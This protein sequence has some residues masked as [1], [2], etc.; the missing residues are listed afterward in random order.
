VIDRWRKFFRLSRREKVLLG[1]A[2]PL[3]PATALALRV[4]GFRRLQA[5]LSG[6]PIRSETAP[7]NDAIEQARRTARM[8]SIAARRGLYQ[9]NCLPQSLV[10]WALLRRQAIESDLRIGVRKENGKFEAHAWIEIQ[11]AALNDLA[12]VGLRFAPFAGAIDLTMRQLGA[13]FR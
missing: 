2:V 9:A 4:I 12:D 5:A 11:G 13:K 1:L 8:V 6:I 3:L 7:V 10:L